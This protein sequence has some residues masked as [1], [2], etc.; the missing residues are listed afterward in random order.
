MKAVVAYIG[1]NVTIKGVQLSIS[2]TRD[3][4]ENLSGTIL[5]RTRNLT[6]FSILTG[7]KFLHKEFYEETTPPDLTGKQS[8]SSYKIFMKNM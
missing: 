5:K 7:L 3:G 2:K 1:S 6:T 8:F 4:V